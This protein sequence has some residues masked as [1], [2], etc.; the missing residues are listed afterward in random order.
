[1]PNWICRSQ[2]MNRIVAALLFA[3]A[4]ALAAQ[5]AQFSN[6]VR[7][8]IKTDAP[9]VALTNARIIDGTGAPAKEA[10]TLIIRNGNIAELGDTARIKVPEGATTID[11]SGKSVIPGLVMGTSTP[12]TPWRP[13]S[14]DSLASA[15]R[16]SISPAV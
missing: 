14:T 15:S 10:Q 7:G 13:G 6:T 5:P 16:G 4:T 11:L 12:I 3:S 8:F 1:M 2:E 9:V